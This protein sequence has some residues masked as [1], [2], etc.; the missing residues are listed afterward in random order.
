MSQARSKLEK[1]KLWLDVFALGVGILV[2]IGGSV[3]GL[4][5]WTESRNANRLNVDTQQDADETKL[6]EFL[7]DKDNSSLSGLWAKFQN[8]TNTLV[9]AQK[10]ILLLISTNE[11]D[12]AN[13]CGQTNS[14][15]L[16]VQGLN[17]YIWDG[18][19]FYDDRRVRLRK[20]YNVVE[21]IY[22]QIQYSFD[23]N[24][25]GQL[26]KDD[27]EG[28]IGCLDG[29]C[30]HPLFL[31]ALQDDHDNSFPSEEYKK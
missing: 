10:Q 5:A 25:K 28:W 12:F 27:F 11:S 13:L 8:E 29:L 26:T 18:G 2:G 16:T 1:V 15:P 23:A 22:D 6:D 4:I 31:A 24:K 17:D 21:W 7:L 3:V 19:H 20:A 14:I 9:V 30:T